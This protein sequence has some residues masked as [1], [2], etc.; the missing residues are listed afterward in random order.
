M[1]FSGLYR[2]YGPDVE[3][4]TMILANVE[5][6]MVDRLINRTMRIKHARMEKAERNRA[7][8]LRARADLREIRARA[9]A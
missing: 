2:L 8:S 4:I 9:G 1:T 5:P 7:F 6:W 3:R